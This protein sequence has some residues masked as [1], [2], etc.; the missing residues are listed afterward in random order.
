MSKRC[1]SAAP[2][3][4][5]R[6]RRRLPSPR[7]TRWPTP[8]PTRADAD[9]LADADADADALGVEDEHFGP[10]KVAVVGRP[11]VGKSSL[12]NAVLGEER[13]VVH[14]AAGTTRDSIATPLTWRGESLQLADTAGSA[15]AAPA[16]RAARS[17]T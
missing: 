12:L 6:R 8:P 9:A 1:A 10:L 2:S 4:R 11:N 15:S 7:P 17:S 3:P 14:E 13:V 5:R 16:A